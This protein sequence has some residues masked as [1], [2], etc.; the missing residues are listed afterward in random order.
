[1]SEYDFEYLEHLITQ[2]LE[3]ELDVEESVSAFR[4]HLIAEHGE[5]PEPI[6]GD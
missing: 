3:G 1:M 2:V 5:I 6:F 4:R